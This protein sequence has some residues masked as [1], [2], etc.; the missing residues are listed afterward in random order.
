ML[1]MNNNMSKINI[2]RYIMTDGKSSGFCIYP[3]GA[4]FGPRN[5]FDYEIV[6]LESGSATWTYNE[7]S[8]KINTDSILIT[9]PGS[10]EFFEWDVL[11]QTG[12]YFIHFNLD[13]ENT[14]DIVELKNPQNW[15]F[16]QTLPQNNI[17]KPLLMHILWLLRNG[18]KDTDPQLQGMLQQA[19]L[20]FVSGVF[21]LEQVMPNDLPPAIERVF[22][23]IYENW[24]TFPLSKTDLPELA[25]KAHISATHL[26]RLFNDTFKLSPMQVLGLIRLKRAA[27]LL[28]RTNYPVKEVAHLTGF[29]SQYHFS[30]SFKKAYGINP[31]TYRKDSIAGKKLPISSIIVKT[32]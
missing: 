32:F 22:E 30:R 27:S 3:P 18:Y 11:G 16:V 13:R 20:V 24:K 12:H 17:L 4:T 31:T 5:T 29:E 10:T 15:P 19:I 6:W 14:P 26:C 28:V 8:Y 9:K 25:S 1:V 7:N 21:E 23:Y 2:M